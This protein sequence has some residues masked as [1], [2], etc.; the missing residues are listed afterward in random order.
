MNIYNTM[1]L[2]ILWIGWTGFVFTPLLHNI[3]GIDL[4]S[5]MLT[6]SILSLICIVSFEAA[7]NREVNK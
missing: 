3:L 7:F 2:I 4:A 1:V 6:A 5:S